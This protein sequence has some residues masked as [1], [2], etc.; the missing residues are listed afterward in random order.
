[1]PQL[2]AARRQDL[3]N[4]SIST[5]TGATISTGSIRGTDNNGNYTFME[6]DPKA[7]VTT[8]TAGYR[9]AKVMYKMN[10][11]TKTVAGENSCMILPH[12]TADDVHAHLDALTKHI[13]SM[14]ESEQD[15]IIKGYHLD[16]VTFV[17]PDQ[18]SIEA[19]IEALEAVAVSGRIN[20]EMIQEWFDAYMLD[21]L[22][23]LI[24]EKLGCDIELLAEPA[25][26]LAM[27]VKIYADSYAKMASNTTQY[28]PEQATLLKQAIEKAIDTD[29]G[30]Q[31]V[32][33]AKMVDKLD[34]M[35]SP[36]NTMELLGF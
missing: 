35:I 22:S 21:G 18:V 6:Y 7:P 15:K 8:N 16:K 14:L 11:K 26:K 10:M 3:N 1:M 2:T 31:A 19:I 25:S 27:Q 34:K 24:A 12:V 30:K 33:T 29:E 5:I 23:I 17:E 28:Q 20:K 4:M 9:V 32:M 13:V 36:V